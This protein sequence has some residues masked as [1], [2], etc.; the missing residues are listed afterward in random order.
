MRMTLSVQLYV[1][2]FSAFFGWFG[3]VVFALKMVISMHQHT[4]SHY[5]KANWSCSRMSGTSQIF[6]LHNSLD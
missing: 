2:D 1:F 6:P 3:R 5:K 4:E